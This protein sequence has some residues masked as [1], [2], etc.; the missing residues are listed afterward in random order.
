MLTADTITDAQI[1]ALRVALQ[2]TADGSVERPYRTP[3]GMVEA[4]AIYHHISVAL[5]ERDAPPGGSIAKSRSR[6][7]EVLNA[8]NGS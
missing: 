6:C 4:E 8:R 7:A 3:T 1:H 5:G 2:N